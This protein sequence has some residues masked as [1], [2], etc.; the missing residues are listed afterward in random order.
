MTWWVPWRN[1]YEPLAAL[2]D[3]GDGRFELILH[4]EARLELVRAI[5][6]EMALRQARA[7]DSAFPWAGL[8]LEGTLE[9]VLAIDPQNEVARQRLEQIR[10]R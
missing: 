10:N 3:D 2:D 7:P 8:E 4:R 9:E 1:G 5:N 6:A